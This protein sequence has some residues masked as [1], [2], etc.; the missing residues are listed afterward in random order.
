M[1]EIARRVGVAAPSAY[2]HFP[3]LDA[4]ALAL[5]E[6]GFAELAARLETAPT[7]AK[8]QL[9]GVG[10]AYVR[11]AL[12]NPGLYRLMFGDGLKTSSTEHHALRILR[13]RTYERVKTG[14]RARLREEQVETAALFLW[15]LV[16]GLAL[17]MID[18]RIGKPANHDAVIMSV[19]RLAGTGLPSASSQL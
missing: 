14:L 10:L 19:L 2:H 13:E 3:K 7:N 4:I 5:A 1:R 8:G 12:D 18:G 16:H 11:F 9:S 15:S 6:E 17:L